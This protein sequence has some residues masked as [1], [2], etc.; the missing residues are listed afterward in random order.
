[1]AMKRILLFE[2]ADIP[3]QHARVVEQTRRSRSRIGGRQ[4]GSLKREDENCREPAHLEL[5]VKVL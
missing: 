5:L 4:G 3:D 1:M 2:P